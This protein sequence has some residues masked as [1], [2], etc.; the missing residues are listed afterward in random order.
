MLNRT[1]DHIAHGPRGLSPAL[2]QLDPAQRLRLAKSSQKVGRMLGEMPVVDV[3]PATPKSAK[4]P[5]ASRPPAVPTRPLNWSKENGKSSRAPS[6]APVLRYKQPT[7]RRPR[8][9]IPDT[10]TLVSPALPPIPSPSTPRAPIP[11][12]STP[13]PPV[14]SPLTPRAQS[15]M[16]ELKNCDTIRTPFTP[17]Y[18]SPLAPMSPLSPIS[19]PDIQEHRLRSLRRLARISRAFRDTIV[20]ELAIPCLGEANQDIGNVKTY[21]DLYRMSV[22]FPSRR[23]QASAGRRRSHSVGEPQPRLSVVD[24]RPVYSAGPRTS[25]ILPSSTP[26]TQYTGS[27]YFLALG[28]PPLSSYA[29]RSPTT[30]DSP[31]QQQQSVAQA[32]AVILGADAQL[33]DRFRQGFAIRAP[34]TPG[35][36]P[37]V[38]MPYWVRS[39]YRA[40]ESMLTPGAARRRRTASRPP[41]TPR[42]IRRERRQGWGGEWRQGKLGK[43]VEKLREVGAQPQTPAGLPYSARAEKGVDYAATAMLGSHAVVD[44]EAVV[45]VDVAEF[46]PARAAVVE[47]P[48]IVVEQAEELGASL[49]ENDETDIPL[50][51]AYCAYIDAQLVD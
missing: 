24:V 22:R 1:A 32:K 34:P 26:S 36:S 47:V 50:E 33:M 14:L 21:L 4:A 6:H 10:L 29:P 3:Y 20:E 27:P 43:V 35:R 44:M 45:P 38:S 41:P 42:T 11:S 49:D 23:P 25:F 37:R 17:D 12:L 30:D 48:I 39:A 13:R 19:T 5:L 7:I 40:R 28:S 8:K 31:L 9:A 51:E 15:Y 46:K 2:Q 16:S 18:L